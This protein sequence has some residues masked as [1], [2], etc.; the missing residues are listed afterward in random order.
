MLGPAEK[1]VGSVAAQLA[2]LAE[3]LPGLQQT[4]GQNRLRAGDAQ[5]TAAAASE[6]ANGVQQ[7]LWPCTM[8]PS[9]FSILMP[10]AEDLFLLS[11]PPEAEQMPVSIFVSTLC[12]C[13]LT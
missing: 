2:V 11:V 8:L 10:F 6:E 13:I 5:Q 9:A 3:G 7:V 1:N 12:I 4:A